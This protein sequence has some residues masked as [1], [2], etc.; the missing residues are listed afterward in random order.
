[1]SSIEDKIIEVIKANVKTK[2]RDLVTKN[3]RLREDLGLDSINFLAVS[4]QIEEKVGF[5]FLDFDVDFN[6]NTVEDVIKLV[7]L[8]Q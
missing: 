4:I 8:C 7:E 3:A 1:M 2:K 6:V 5:S